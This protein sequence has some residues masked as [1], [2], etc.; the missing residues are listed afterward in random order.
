MG[1]NNVYVF[2]LGSDSKQYKIESNMSEKF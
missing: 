1:D 2:S